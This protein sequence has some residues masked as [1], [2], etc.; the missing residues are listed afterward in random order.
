MPLLG[1]PEMAV[2]TR[3]PHL[4]S[5]EGIAERLAMLADHAGDRM[6]EIEISVPDFGSATDFTT[7]LEAKRDYYGRLAELGVGWIDLA[8]PWAPAPAALDYIAAFAEAF[9]R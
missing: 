8:V 3:T 5:V 1:P 2:T 9:I 7:G 6:G 4:D